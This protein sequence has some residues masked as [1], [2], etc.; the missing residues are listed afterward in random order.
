M[1]KIKSFFKGIIYILVYFLLQIIIYSIFYKDIYNKNNLVLSNCANI[2]A[3][4][5]LLFIFIIIF[6][7]KLI[8]DFNDFKKNHKKILT[9]NIKYWAIGLC[10]MVIS[11]IIINLIVGDIA[12]NEEANR[13]I[14]LNSPVSSIIS[15]VIIAPIIEE[16]ITRKT[17]KDAITNK[18]IYILFSGILFGL[19]HLLLADSL[20]ELL[21]II[22]YAALGCAFAKMYYDT[23]NLWTSIFFHSFHNLIAIILIFIGV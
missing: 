7:K 21:Y 11:N 17:F 3:D 9:N 4:L 10:I 16:L 20:V 1:Y 22:P 23:D 2:F 13:T 14:L 15:M 6:R 5:L 8:P 18:Y 19:L 12:I